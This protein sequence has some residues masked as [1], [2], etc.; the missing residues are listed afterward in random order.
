MAGRDH[1]EIENQ[2]PPPLRKNGF[3]SEKNQDNQCAEQSSEKEGMKKAS[4]SKKFIG[5]NE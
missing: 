4:M 1:K 3:R 2:S 5:R